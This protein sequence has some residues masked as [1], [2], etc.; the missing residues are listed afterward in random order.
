MAPV[1]TCVCVRVYDCLSQPCPISH[2]SARCVCVSTRG[3]LSFACVTG[4]V[5]V[6]PVLQAGKVPV[7]PVPES[8]RG[9]PVH[10]CLGEFVFGVGDPRQTESACITFN[11]ILQNLKKRDSEQNSYYSC[12]E[13]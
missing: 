5:C 11:W 13:M 9:H 10:L 3:E 2:D 8:W 12:P 7:L 1:C 4:N 6:G